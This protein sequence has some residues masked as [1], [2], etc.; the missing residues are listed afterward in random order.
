MKGA[1]IKQGNPVVSF[2]ETVTAETPLTVMGKSANKHNRLSMTAEPLSKKFV[3]FMDN[4]TIAVDQDPKKRARVLADEDNWD[5]V[6]ARKIWSFGI[7]DGES[8]VIVD[9]TK[10]VQYLN[11][12]KD[13]V[14]T[15]FKQAS[16]A[17]VLC[18]EAMRGI[19]FNL[20]DVT[21]HADS[22]H[23]GA[24]QIM[25]PMKRACYG[26]QIASSPKLQEPMYLCDITVPRTAISGVYSTLNIR[27]GEVAEE[28]DRPGTPIVNIKAYLPVLESFG[29]TGLL[30]ENTSGQAFPQMIFSHW[31]LMQ[32]EL[33]DEARQPYESGKMREI[34]LATRKRKGLKEEMPLFANYFDKL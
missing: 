7:L 21:L 22:I 29:F 12:I 31:Q 13:S 24:G 26:C 2:C 4:G 28:T 15:A 33:Y 30:R 3:E 25:P 10:G 11:E 5:I 1:P 20:E 19:R 17:G 18:D 34:I 16:C 23:R 27:R 14:T 32:G 8:N 9:M 6:S